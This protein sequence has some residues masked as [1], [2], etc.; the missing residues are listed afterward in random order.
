MRE[1][2]RFV[3]QNKRASPQPPLLALRAAVLQV[4][5]LPLHHTLRTQH[6]NQRQKAAALTARRSHRQR[7]RNRAAA[8]DHYASEQEREYNTAQHANQQ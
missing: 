3:A 8:D 4:L 6:S 1:P 5:R 7:V 2:R